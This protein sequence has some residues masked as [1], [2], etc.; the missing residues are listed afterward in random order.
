MSKQNGQSMPDKILRLLSDGKR[1][2]IEELEALAPYSDRQT[3]RNAVCAIRR[4][5]K[6][7]GE[8]VV[9]VRRG[10]KSYY[11]HVR[12]LFNPYDGRT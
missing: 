7:R 11:Q 10:W 5:L 8:D 2:P 4:R 12:L 3:I 6:D 1:H 9:C